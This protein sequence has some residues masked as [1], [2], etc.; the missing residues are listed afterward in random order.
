MNDFCMMRDPQGNEL[1]PLG[2]MQRRKFNPAGK[3]IYGFECTIQVKDLDATS[4]AV[5]A[6]GGKIVMPRCAVPTVGWLIKFL[7]TEGNLVVAMQP[8][9]AAK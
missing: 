4:K 2:A 1:A 3:E 8:D 6:Q 9:P 5:T 7:D